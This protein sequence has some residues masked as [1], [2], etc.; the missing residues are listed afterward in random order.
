MAAQLVEQAQEFSRLVD[1]FGAFLPSHSMMHI[2]EEALSPARIDAILHEV[3]KLKG[4]VAYQDS[5]FVFDALQSG[6]AIVREILLK[7]E[8]L[9]PESIDGVIAAAQDY[10]LGFEKYLQGGG[11]T[12]LE[13]ALEDNRSMLF[14]YDPASRKLKDELNAELSD[15][16]VGYAGACAAV[17][18]RLHKLVEGVRPQDLRK[19]DSASAAA[20]EATRLAAGVV[21]SAEVKQHVNPSPAPGS[22]A[23][24]PVRITLVA[25]SETR[26]GVE[27]FKIKDAIVQEASDTVLMR[28]VARGVA[29]GGSLDIPSKLTGVDSYVL[30]ADDFAAKHLP[31]L[32]IEGPDWYVQ[33]NAADKGG[34]DGVDVNLLGRRATVD[35]MLDRFRWTEAASTRDARVARGWLKDKDTLFDERSFDAGSF[36]GNAFKLVD[37]STGVTYLADATKVALG[38]LQYCLSRDPYDRFKVLE[39]TYDDAIIRDG[40]TVPGLANRAGIAGQALDCLPAYC[41]DADAERAS[42]VLSVVL[43][44]RLAGKIVVTTESG[45]CRYSLLDRINDVK[46]GLYCVYLV[47]H[48]TLCLN[49][50]GGDMNATKSLVPV[51]APVVAL[52]MPVQVRPPKGQA[53]RSQVLS[54]LENRAGA[55][56][57]ARGVLLK[58]FKAATLVQYLSDNP[59]QDQDVKRAMTVALQESRWREL[60]N[61]AKKIAQLSRLGQSVDGLLTRAPT[62]PQPDAETGALTP[63]QP[64]AETGALT[65][66]QPDAETGALTPPEPNAETGA[67]NPPLP[68]ALKKTVRFA[69][70]GGA[71]APEAGALQLGQ[72]SR[73]L[74]DLQRLGMLPLLVDMIGADGAKLPSD[75]TSLVDLDQSLRQLYDYILQTFVVYVRSIKTSVD[76]LETTVADADALPLKDAGKAL[77]TVKRMQGVVQTTIECLHTHSKPTS[78]DDDRAQC[79]E[80]AHAT[81]GELDAAIASL[82]R[83]LRFQEVL[84]DAAATADPAACDQK[85]RLAQ[86]LLKTKD[87][88]KP[89]LLQRLNAKYQLEIEDAVP[90]Y[91]RR[92]RKI[93]AL[94]DGRAQN[95]YK[96]LENVQQQLAKV[97]AQTNE[98][99]AAADT[100]DKRRRLVDLK[101]RKLG[102]MVERMIAQFRSYYRLHTGF[103]TRDFK[104][105]ITTLA[106]YKGLKKDEVDKVKAELFVKVETFAAHFDKTFQA[107]FF[108]NM[109]IKEHMEVYELARLQDLLDKSRST[110]TGLSEKIIAMYKNKIGFAETM[111]AQFML[112]YVIKAIRFMFIWL[113]LFL[114]GAVF[115]NMWVDRVYERHLPPPNLAGL[116]IMFL[117]IELALNAVLW[118]SLWTVIYVYKNDDNNF[119]VDGTLF[120]RML[121]D[122]AATTSLIFV[123]GLVVAQVIKKHTTFNYANDGVQP[124][125]AYKEILLALSGFA[126]IQPAFLMA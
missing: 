26:D 89:D 52:S 2:D 121:V 8:T 96:E 88:R 101:A 60:Y 51:G 4:H 87:G 80:L 58:M 50:P 17:L 93:T 83:I 7:W 35:V 11:S 13:Q 66:P 74:L 84:G 82:L 39:L 106:K 104:D 97:T 85:M 68:S 69:G 72:I 75:V 3:A 115:T 109:A 31:W 107:M 102:G 36:N 98:A 57:A 27:R 119:I 122:Y 44:D 117:L 32:T 1:E 40:T 34:L 6:L 116:L 103:I 5:R 94:A 64:N 30:D 125:A 41:V 120:R 14:S 111:D 112:M 46:D 118:V 81:K 92:L 15:V 10:V 59:P 28:S 22:P 29:K 20:R 67:P 56:P 95:I 63:P 18:T 124:I 73:Y 21:R 91:L 62:P 110:Y 114:A 43:T 47:D 37:G 61:R 78:A 12:E 25:Y 23:P 65:P 54:L 123:V 90:D 45:R 24:V 53:L 99:I 126:L 49:V 71:A 105:G 38:G 42:K 48:N 76:Q 19:L 9:K 86:D 77:A 100:A 16:E 79:I 55:S 33:A 70:G 108:T 113:S